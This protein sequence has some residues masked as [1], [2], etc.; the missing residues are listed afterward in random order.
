MKI[1]IL[2]VGL[3]LCLGS[4]YAEWNIETVFSAGNV[5]GSVSLVLDASDNPCIAYYCYGIYYAHWNGSAWDIECVEFGGDLGGASLALDTSGN[6]HISYCSG[7]VADTVFIKY[8][9]W[10]G[11]N[12]QISR[13]DQSG[14]NNNSTT[15]SLAL[16][17]SDY[18]HISYHDPIYLASVLWY[19]HWDGL[20]WNVDYIDSGGENSLVLDDDDYPRIS[21]QT[22]MVGYWDL[23]YA[24]YDGITWHTETVDVLD[25]C[26]NGSSLTLDS[27][28]YPHIAYNSKP[29]EQDHRLKYVHWDGSDWQ[30]ET[31]DT[32]EYLPIISLTLEANDKPCIAYQCDYNGMQY[33]VKN[34]GVWIVENV[35]SDYYSAGGTSL[36]L[37]SQGNPR[38]AYSV[39]WPYWDLRYAWQDYT[40]V[41]ENSQL[42]PSV[43]VC[44]AIPNPFTSSTMV[45][46]ELL[47]PGYVEL[48][49]FNLSGALIDELFT[50]EVPVGPINCCL[51]GSNLPAGVYI[52][53]LQTEREVISVRLVKL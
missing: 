26:G 53:R 34:E 40:R 29:W 46:F 13:I 51:E 11:S 31:V 16:D 37:D 15:T 7:G 25:R 38:I 23:K 20:E 39:C 52:T 43:V 44:T 2:L 14:T 47:E 41:E 27:N 10:D 21:Y 50:G 4:T 17:S 33:A 35:D 12:W 9:Y 19:A 32:L 48:L 49:V 24:Y 42:S 45:S 30:I 5:Y 22:G 8:A 18:P 28:G 1:K 3:I 6:P 36:T